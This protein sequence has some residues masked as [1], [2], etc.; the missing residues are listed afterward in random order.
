VTSNEV[1]MLAV[2]LT[3]GMTLSNLLH[4]Y[5]EWQDGRRS[6][7]RSLQAARRA[8]GALYLSSFRLYRLQH[9]RPS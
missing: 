1:L 6:L 4:I 7:A 5:W 2:G 8:G 9:R 3:F